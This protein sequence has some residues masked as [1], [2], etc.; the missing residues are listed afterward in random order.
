MRISALNPKYFN[1]ALRVAAGA[2]AFRSLFQSRTPQGAAGWSVF[3]L[4]YPKVALP[5]FFLF[6]QKKMEYYGQHKVPHSSRKHEQKLKHFQFP[7]EDGLDKLFQ[8]E[9]Y[10][11]LK[12]NDL[13][14]LIDGE[15]FYG[16][17][18]GALERA[19]E[20]ILF[21][22][23]IFREDEAGLRFIELLI[24]KARAGVKV[25]VLYEWIGARLSV[26]QV[27][28][29][30]AAG[31]QVAFFSPGKKEKFQPNFRNHR[32]T[33]VIDGKVGYFGGMNIGDDYLGKYR[34][35]GHWR[36]TN[37]RVK[38][39]ALLAAQEDFLRD[40]YWASNHDCDIV[41][42]GP[43]SAGKENAMVSGSS[44]TTNMP[45]ALL[46]HLEII[47][48]AKER[49][50]LANPYFV[51]PQSLF[52]ALVGA[53]LKGVDVRL[54]LPAN[55]D[56]PL[57][58]KAS[59]VYAQRLIKYGVR[60]FTYEKGFLHEKVML[61]DNRIATIG[62]VNLDYRSMYLD[63]ENS[64]I[65]DSQKI[66]HQVEDMFQNDFADSTELTL[67]DFEKMSI[68]EKTMQRLAHV[69]SPAL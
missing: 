49:L 4:S 62:S 50:W 22:I 65:T 13:H 36:D 69:F 2:L 48:S 27:E 63:F 17:L 31:I 51:P 61:M 15:A 16:D 41:I 40:W 64:V 11:L 21:Q 59:M 66:I 60:I 35:I 1:T 12:G 29:M 46:Q 42:K 28:A 38:G 53:C 24:E 52:D 54:I 26:K 19:E 37:I 20:Y 5:A 25:F 33:I 7:A 8:Q 55:S 45:L 23:Y 47:N 67:E 3:L 9:N 14:L 34:K 39:P 43:Y 18:L 56:N 10:G 58:Q 6:G 30:K 32:K 68:V 57:V 44:P